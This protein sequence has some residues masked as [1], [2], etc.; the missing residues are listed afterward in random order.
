MREL[1]CFTPTT[2]K[3]RL[4]YVTC[5]DNCSSCPFLED[6]SELNLEKLLIRAK[7]IFEFFCYQKIMSTLISLMYLLHNHA[8]PE[9]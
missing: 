2:H 1:F 7:Q 8:A 3:E 9:Y 6:V 5:K 4:F